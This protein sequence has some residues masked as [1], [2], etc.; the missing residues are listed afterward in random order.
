VISTKRFTDRAAWYH[1]YRPDYP[2]EVVTLLRE[3]AGLTMDAVVA[4]IGAGTGISTTPFLS[5][6]NVVYAVE[7]NDAMRA[8]ADRFLGALPRFHSLKGTAEATGLPTSSI[9]FAIAAQAFHW[10]DHAAARREFRRILKPDGKAVVI[11][12][13][14]KQSGPYNE[15]FES[16]LRNYC[17]RYT[18][19]IGP[20]MRQSEAALSSFFGPAGF[21]SVRLDHHQEFDW[22]GAKGRLLSVSYAPQP[23]TPDCERL[24]ERLRK[25]FDRRQKDGK[26]RLLY[27]TFVHFGELTE[28]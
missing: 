22:E 23:G 24:L 15:E 26:V 13:N 6:A 16:L 19:E 17:E 8:E 21:Q 2:A 12:N 9:D 3:R 7:P 20:L 10:F 25:V 5:N 1:S 4:D 27:N 18:S 11:W 14:R 28:R